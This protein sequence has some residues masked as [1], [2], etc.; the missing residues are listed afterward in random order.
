MFPCRYGRRNSMN[1]A[2][3]T[4]ALGVKGDVVVG[5]GSG[6]DANTGLSDPVGVFVCAVPYTVDCVVL[7]VLGVCCGKSSAY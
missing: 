2:P 3:H 6:V 5:V 4:V 7:S 1:P